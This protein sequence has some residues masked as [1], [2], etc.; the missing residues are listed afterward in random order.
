MSPCRLGPCFDG[1]ARKGAALACPVLPSAG[2]SS[3]RHQPV[4]LEKLGDC[5]RKS[6]KLSQEQEGV[7]GEG[8]WGRGPQVPEKH[9]AS[10]RAHL[11]PCLLEEM[12]APHLQRAGEVCAAFTPLPF[13]WCPGGVREG[14]KTRGRDQPH[15]IYGELHAA[16][17]PGWAHWGCGGKGIFHSKCILEGVDQ[18][19]LCREIKQ[20]LW[21]GAQRTLYHVWGQDKP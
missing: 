7:T 21:L 1:G 16:A 11:N 14:W 6:W 17:G 4:Q 18:D 15:S 20:V 19:I 5:N 8:G 3:C 2:R 9:R 10:H 13:C 12:S